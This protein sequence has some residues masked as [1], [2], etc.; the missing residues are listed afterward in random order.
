MII[1][2]RNLVTNPDGNKPQDPLAVIG[3]GVHH[4]GGEEPATLLSEAQEREVIKAIDRDHVAKG[5][6]GFGY[7]GITFVSGRSYYCGDGQ[8]AHVAKRNHE[9]RGWVLH[10]N[11][12]AT[13]PG[14]AQMDG[15]REA[16]LAE[17][18]K[19]AYVAVLPIK[20][21]KEWALPGEG[22]ECPG[23]LV[24]RDWEAFL[25][26]A[27]PRK[28]I[29]GDADGG[30]EVAGNQLLVWNNGV[31]VFAFGDFEGTSPGQLAK[32]YGNKWE[33]LRR[34]APITPASD[35]LAGAVWSKNKGD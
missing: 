25:Y 5:F 3:I 28:F 15:L 31:C 34:G 2:A 30:I 9:L 11:F 23:L 20:G 27:P 6:G 18:K 7:H 26:P 35:D 16:L 22:T 21:H 33:W 32:L 14:Q 10:G 29:A 13:L 1:D 12:V 24:P 8:R 4:T 19:F 17:R